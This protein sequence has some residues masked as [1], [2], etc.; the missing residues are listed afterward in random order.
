MTNQ[1]EGSLLPL[2][3]IEQC[4][5]K[6]VL[7]SSTFSCGI[8]GIILS[9]RNLFEIDQCA[10]ALVVGSIDVLELRV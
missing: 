3:I 10:F 8:H 6:R 5:K 7:K 2:S 1:L 4:F 9:F